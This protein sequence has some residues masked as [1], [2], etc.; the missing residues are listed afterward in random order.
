[1]PITH[2][3]I[4]A[5]SVITIDM[6]EILNALNREDA[7][8]LIELALE[9]EANT[10]TTAIVLTGNG[11]FSAGGNIH[12][13]LELARSS[14]EE[15][16]A[17]IHDAFQ[18]LMRVLVRLSKPTIA[19]VGG[20]AVGVGFDLAL[21]CDVRFVSDD[22]WFQQGWGRVGLVPGTGQELLLRRLAPT[23]LWDIL[24]G[25]KVLADEANARGLAIHVSGSSLDGAIE[26]ARRLSRLPGNTLAAYCSLHRRELQDGLEAHMERALELQYAL[27]TS[28]E[29]QHRALAALNRK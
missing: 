25:R 4:D 22:G 9:A 7:F 19:A 29:F 2:T 18:E 16:R 3:T 23:L 6:P 13:L 11:A 15:I 17:Y 20:P 26:M 27:L 21:A 10:E 5:A 8:E 14:K 28:E 24:D 1:M 12:V